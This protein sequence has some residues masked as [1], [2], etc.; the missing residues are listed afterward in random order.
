MISGTNIM[1]GDDYND[2]ISAMGDNW[3]CE[4]CGKEIQPDEDGNTWGYFGKGVQ[5]SH[6]FCYIGK[7]EENVR[8]LEFILFS[9]H[10]CYRPE[11]INKVTR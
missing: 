5:P 4:V 10:P 9:L 8:R 11:N 6:V 1:C 7:L 3:K 2:M